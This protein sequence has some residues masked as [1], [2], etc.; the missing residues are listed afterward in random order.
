MDEYELHFGVELE[1]CVK[2]SPDC[3]SR[4]KQRIL[5]HQHLFALNFKQ[6]MELLLLNGFI[7]LTPEIPR[8]AIQEGKL[9]AN[10]QT[11]YLYP[12][13]HGNP[14]LAHVVKPE[15]HANISN[16][17]YP[18]LISD[19]T[20][21]CGDYETDRNYVKPFSQTK[22]HGMTFNDSFAF[23]FVTPVMKL[24]L[25]E[26]TV[27]K[28][29]EQVEPYLTLINLID[30]KNCFVVNASTGFHVNVS[31]L[32]RTTNET[33]DF[34]NPIL[35]NILF[36]LY[37]S[38]EA[39]HYYTHMRTRKPLANA[40]N[41]EYFSFWAQP[42]SILKN[43]KKFHK[44]K[45]IYALRPNFEHFSFLNSK[46][47]SLHRKERNGKKD[48]LEFRGYQAEIDPNLLYQHTTNCLNIVK[49]TFIA[50]KENLSLSSPPGGEPAEH[51]TKAK[52]GSRKTKTKP[53]PKP[54]PKASLR[55]RYSTRRTTK[56]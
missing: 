38:F 12:D 50:Y 35:A 21:V 14:V 1:L 56:S 20:I 37:S 9:A 51:E 27:D 4:E 52:G 45:N 42:V 46:H 48:I 5:Q 13:K 49:D 25:T 41:P 6:K 36:E 19:S 18:L 2:T 39:N 31:L 55:L 11:R 15:T 8:I 22:E 34:D 30:K 17:K 24:P 54:K 40:E 47:A 33:V 32:N 53:K 16:Y 26:I 44:H 29:K 10:T 43:A 23:E 3:A 7:H 28:V